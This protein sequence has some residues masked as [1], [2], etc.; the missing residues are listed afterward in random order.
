M[1]AVN[2]RRL[3]RNKP[4]AIN[5]NFRNALNGL[6]VAL[7]EKDIERMTTSL[8]KIKQSQSVSEE[9]K[10]F[11][12]NLVEETKK[13]MNW[14]PE[15]LDIHIMGLIHNAIAKDTDTDKQKEHDK[16]ASKT[17][18]QYGTRE[19]WLSAMCPIVKHYELNI[20][21]ISAVKDLSRLPTPV[22]AVNINARHV[23]AGACKSTLNTSITEVNAR[24]RRALMKP[25]S[26]RSTRSMNSTKLTKSKV[27]K[28]N[29]VQKVGR[30]KSRKM[31]VGARGGLYYC[32]MRDGKKV[33]VYVRQ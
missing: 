32:K 10:T 6:Q 26:S 24:A 12:E 5:T 22:P 7:A 1:G 27:Q 33:K 8:Q 19:Q 14:E 21:D 9:D 25:K 13:Q 16:I 11:Y 2:P 31:Y 3:G 28:V 17:L 4:N 15:Y 20:A 18:D 30:V 29:K 23:L